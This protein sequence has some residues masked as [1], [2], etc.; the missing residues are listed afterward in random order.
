MSNERL[1]SEE[2]LNEVYSDYPDLDP[3]F[4]EDY[5]L[6]VDTLLD[7]WKAKTLKAVGEWLGKQRANTGREVFIIKD[8]E[9]AELK[10]GRL[11]E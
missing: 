10:Q 9:L 5:L 6:E 4:Y 1:L 2:I 7:Y 3:S 8:S 11:P